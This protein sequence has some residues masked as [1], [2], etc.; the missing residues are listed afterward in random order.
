MHS[1]CG[2]QQIMRGFMNHW[3]GCLVD[4]VVG[5]LDCC[6]GHQVQISLI[7]VQVATVPYQALGMPKYSR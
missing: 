1:N 7:A 2:I 4:T 3:V 5:S 6:M